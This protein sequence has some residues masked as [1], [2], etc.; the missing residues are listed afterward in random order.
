[1]KRIGMKMLLGIL[2]VMILAMLILTKISGDTSQ[3]IINDKIGE[4]MT[5]ELQANVNEINNYLNVVKATTEN[6]SRAVG[7]TYQNT[8]MEVYEKMLTN[9]IWD[10][11]L[12]MG[13]GLWFEPYLFDS[14]QK[15]TG[16][17]WYKDG[18]DTRLTYD[19]SNADYDYFSQE[20]YTQ[21]S[22][23]ARGAAITDPYYD[24]TLDV[25]MASCSAPIYNDENQFI[26][27]VTVDIE[28]S[29]I[30]KLVQDIQTGQNG[31]AM[32]ITENGTYL[33]CEDNGKVISGLNISQ[34]NN[35]SLAAAGKQISGSEDGMAVF[36]EG[37]EPYNLYYDT[38]PG[39]LWTLMIKIPQAEINAPT[40]ELIKK[41]GTVCAAAL[42]LCLIA[43]MWQVSSI[44]IN[45]RKVKSFAASLAQGDFTIAPLVSR[46]RDE[47]GQMSKALNGMYSDNKGV[48][49]EI[50]TD[51]EYINSSSRRLS[52]AA[53]E[54]TEQ[55]KRIQKIMHRVNDA[56][57]ASSA[58]TEEVNASVETVNS[59]VAVLAEEIKKNSNK[60]R[61]IKERAREAENRSKQ[62]YDYAT[63]MSEQY[64]KSLSLAMENAKVVEHIS[65]MANLIS[66][67]A[68]QINLLSLNASIE[69][70]RAG[71]HGKGFAV[72]AAEIGRLAGDTSRSVEQIRETIR[73]VEGAFKLL[74]DGTGE[75]VDFLKNTVTPDYDSFNH[76]AKQYNLDAVIIEGIS[77][78]IAE[79]TG[80]IEH[81]M[82]EAGDAV[83]M[84]AEAA[85]S[86]AESS[87]R[88]M[89]SVDE[90]SSVV[91]E[92]SDMS[93]KQKGI[94]EQLNQVVAGFKL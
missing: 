93:K 47:L 89:Q 78:K 36:T 3:A 17:Y 42:I 30:Q 77:S 86:T 54:L 58:S 49:Q 69:A 66:G 41:L 48:I 64:E 5:W 92:V 56:T 83:H 85:Q 65:T 7:A 80:E 22:G 19:Y 39:V 24:P 31:K 73:D 35:P 13:S 29:H 55:F 34:D 1:M 61:E 20:Y 70:A 32:L 76:T 52:T 68:T 74:A 16:P 75:L 60:A 67:I 25:I 33:S 18:T 15:Y 12:V 94:A 84:V 26:G 59:S 62:A 8:D 28:L 37:E 87:S 46:R 63:G 72:V 53:A 43:V 79:M 10:N 50:S 91:T 71:V 57:M 14:T 21:A 90:A 4:Q 40:E 6:I 45:L 38:V 88:V 27:A 81:I 23:G 11:D 2:P 82:H 44:S 51:A 9:I